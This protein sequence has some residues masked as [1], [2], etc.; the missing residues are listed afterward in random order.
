MIALLYATVPPLQRASAAGAPKCEVHTSHF[1]A[2]RGPR[3]GRGLYCVDILQTKTF[4]S[5]RLI[6]QKHSEFVFWQKLLPL[7]FW[8][9]EV[10]FRNY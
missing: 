7:P 3:A 6:C 9:V 8:E 5:T 4:G 2:V 10:R 1:C